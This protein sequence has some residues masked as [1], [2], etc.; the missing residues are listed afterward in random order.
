MTHCLF[1][2]ASVPIIRKRLI[3]HRKTTLE[4]KGPDLVCKESHGQCHPRSLGLETMSEPAGVGGGGDCRR[5]RKCRVLTE[6][7]K[8][9]NA[10]GESMGVAEEG[11]F[12]GTGQP[13]E[14]PLALLNTS[15]E[16]LKESILAREA[17]QTSLGSVAGLGVCQH[18]GR[19]LKKHRGFCEANRKRGTILA[20]SMLPKA[21]KGFPFSRPHF[22]D[23]GVSV[24]FVLLLIKGSM[25]GFGTGTLVPGVFSTTSTGTTG[26][27]HSASHP[28][29][30]LHFQ[31]WR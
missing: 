3:E 9:I 4:M 30:R 27:I 28:K 25:C 24:G 7:T 21:V 16:L 23:A 13:W 8:V 20:G 14:H 2:H 6:I 11:P 5:R 1:G 19:L 10:T 15:N 22:P 12:K 29:V 31:A 26:R 17:G 18:L